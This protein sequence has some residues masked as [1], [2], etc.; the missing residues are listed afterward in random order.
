MPCNDVTEI[1]QIAVD[2]DDRLTAYAFTKKSCGQAVGALSLLSDHLPGKTINEILEIAP[3]FFLQQYTATE[4]I[5]E[6]LALKH[7][8]AVQ[9]ALE[10]LTGKESG[11]PNDLCSAA[12]ISFAEGNTELIAHLAVDLITEKI[13]SCGGCGTCGANRP[14]QV[15][16]NA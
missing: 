6:F 12:E 9:C 14:I 15:P 2:A 10:V 4:E 16:L 1:I 8:I 5:E 11:G 3:E 7:L 13:R